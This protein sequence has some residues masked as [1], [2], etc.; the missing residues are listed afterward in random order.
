LNSTVIPEPMIPTD[1]SIHEPTNQAFDQITVE[2]ESDRPQPE[3]EFDLNF[4]RNVEID[5]LRGRVAS[6]HT[7]LAELETEYTKEKLAVDSVQAAIF[8]LFQIHHRS[9]HRLNLIVEYRCKFLNT[10]INKGEEAADQF[11]EQYQ[12]A[13]A[14]ADANNK[15]ASAASSQRILTEEDQNKINRLWKKLVQLYHPDRFL[16]QPD[17]QIV[18]ENLVGTINQAR[19]EGNIELLSDIAEDPSAFI[20]LQG[21]KVLDLKDADELN[22]LQ[23]LH[24]ALQLEIVN[25]LEMLNTLRD[26]PEFELHSIS[27]KDAN[28]VNEVVDE[29]IMVLSA[30]TKALETE[31]VR[32]QRDIDEFTDATSTNI[33]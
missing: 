28:F 16:N 25:L 20:P 14:E 11:A 10:L 32:L 6:A 22:S 3:A 24:I 30:E 19:D 23:K 21:W 27:R 31:A 5:R 17:K 26:S 9:R 33:D 7:R 8:N 13:R 4:S 1:D 29:R 15:M 18:Y 2:V 12:E